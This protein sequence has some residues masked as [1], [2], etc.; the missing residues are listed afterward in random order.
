MCLQVSNYSVGFVKCLTSVDFC[1][2]NV[3]MPPSSLA[4]MTLST[5]ALPSVCEFF[6]KMKQLNSQSPLV[7]IVPS[8]LTLETSRFA[9]SVYLHIMN[10]CYNNLSLISLQQRFSNCGP[11]TTSGPRVLPLWSF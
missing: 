5:V 4:V 3:H 2:T 8:G 10:D 11:R 1:I 9:Q 7:T 6:K